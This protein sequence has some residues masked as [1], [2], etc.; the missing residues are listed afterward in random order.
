MSILNYFKTAPKRT[1]EVLQDTLNDKGNS[2]C[3]STEFERVKHELEKEENG[4]NEPRKRG[5]YQRWTSK[6]RAD[7]GRFANLHGVA[8]AVRHFKLKYPSITKQTVSDFKRAYVAA[9]NDNVKDVDLLEKKR[10]GRPTLLPPELMD[11]TIDLI[12]NL[13]MKGTPITASI[14]TATVQGI[15]IANDRSLLF[16]H[17][18][19]INLNSDWARNILYRM[20]AQG[21]AMTRHM[22]TTSKMPIAHGIIREAKL[23]F[24]RQIKTAHTNHSVPDELILNFDQTPLSYISVGK[25]TLEVRGTKTVPVAGKGDKRQ[26]TGTFTISKAG[27][28]LPMQLIYEGKTEQCHPRGVE[29][30]DGF[31]VTHTPNHWSNEDKVVELLEKVILPY[32]KNTR[33]NLGLSS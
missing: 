29:F 15:V 27:D 22:T 28:F 25:H 30:P 20:E 5:N 11:K 16:Q 31:N 1:S 12:T 8:S 17:G 18:G 7:I 2:P 10:V 32:V 9:I 23:H 14:I 13:R 24:Q 21:R 4:A 3:T 6:L 19:H 33:E 26:I